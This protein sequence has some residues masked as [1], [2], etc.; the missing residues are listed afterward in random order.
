M[1]RNTTHERINEK[2][3]FQSERLICIVCDRFVERVSVSL[4]VSIL[5]QLLETNLQTEMC[6]IFV[7]TLP[8]MFLHAQCRQ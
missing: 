3:N 8:A 4:M 5:K 1:K 7:Q 6:K 2:H